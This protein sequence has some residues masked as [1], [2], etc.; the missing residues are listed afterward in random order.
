MGEGKQQLLLSLSSFSSK[1][2]VMAPWLFAYGKRKASAEIFN[3]IY[4]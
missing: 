3:L 4:G 2:P 1:N